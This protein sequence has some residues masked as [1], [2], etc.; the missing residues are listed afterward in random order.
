MKRKRDS[1][2][3]TRKDGLEQK[4]ENFWSPMGEANRR[5]KGQWPGSIRN[6]YEV[7]YPRQNQKF[8]LLVLERLPSNS[9]VYHGGSWRLS[10]CHIQE[11]KKKKNLFEMLDFQRIH[12]SKKGLWKRAI[13][14]LNQIVKMS[15]LSQIIR[16][17]VNAPFKDFLI[18]ITNFLGALSQKKDDFSWIINQVLRILWFQAL[19]KPCFENKRYFWINCVCTKAFV[20]WCT[21]K[22][23]ICIHCI[24]IKGHSCHGILPSGY[25]HHGILSRRHLHSLH[26]QTNI[27]H[28]HF[29][30]RYLH[31]K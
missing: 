20:S 31:Q 10:N 4:R 17:Q 19:W 27:S 2:V 24:P 16:F 26:T 6:L 1:R 22:G 14:L 23:G 5:M 12:F 18:V 11:R 3:K 21:H 8:E 15:L 13:S 25:P 29:D 30:K 7:F 9:R 28:L